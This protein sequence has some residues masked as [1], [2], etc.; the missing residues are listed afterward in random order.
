[1]LTIKLPYTCNDPNYPTELNELRRV[2]SSCYRSTYK[3][4]AEGLAEI[5][6]D[7]YCRD[8]FTELDSWFRRSAIYKGIGQFKAD[9]ELAK[10]NKQ[11]FNGSRIF[12]GKRNFMRRVK[13]LITHEEYQEHRIENLYVIGE[14]S[15]YG[16]RKFNFNTDTIIFKPNRKSHYEL[17][18]P[19]LHGKYLKTYQD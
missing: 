14:K 19:N 17:I 3:R 7:H 16:N 6:I 12:G 9:W 10:F 1:M 5:E 18:L 13:G 2:Q 15:P 11:N 8:T 4:A